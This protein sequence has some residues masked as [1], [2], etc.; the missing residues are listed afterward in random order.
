MKV[1][2]HIKWIDPAM[3]F[4]GPC[5]LHNHTMQLRGCD[6]RVEYP[7]LDTLHAKQ[8][9]LAVMLDC[10]AEVMERNERKTR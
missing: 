1:G 8:L 10:L 9:I 5:E 4:R 2:E 3:S 7:E 6:S